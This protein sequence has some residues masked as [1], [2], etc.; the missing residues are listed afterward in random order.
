MSYLGIYKPFFFNNSCNC[1]FSSVSYIVVILYDTWAIGEVPSSLSMKT[2][3]SLYWGNFGSSSENTF[4]N[5]LTMGMLANSL[6]PP[7]T[8][9]MKAR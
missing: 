5:S 4:E 6:F 2:S 8:S 9:T 1:I 7:L 3:T